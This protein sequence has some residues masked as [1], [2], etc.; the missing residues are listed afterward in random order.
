LN[1]KRNRT[2]VIAEAGVNHNGD[3]NIA[4][5]LID[6]ASKSGADYVKFQ[7]FDVDH[8]IL[9][10]TRTATYQKRNLKSNISQ[11]LMLKKYQLAENNYKELINFSKKKKIK[12]L[13]TAFDFKSLNFL[14]KFKLDYIK[15]PSGEITNLPFLK[16]IAK[17]NKKILLST[18]MASVREIKQALR[19]LGSKKKN[20]T[21]MHCTSDYP[22][23]LNDLN[24]NFIKE[25]KKFGYQVGY[26]DHSSS[27]ITPS[28]AVSLG[29]KVIEK[30]FTLSKKF[31]GPDHKAS[32]EPQELIKMIRLIRDTEKMLG[33]KNKII[34]SSEK[35][36]KLLVRKSLV[37][38]IDIKKGEIFN[39]KN[40]T[41][42]RPGTGISPFKIKKFLGKKSPK[43]FSKDQLIK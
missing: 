25:L 34:T 1:L 28:I 16:E 32:L 29:S 11:Y 21:I 2:I 19:V 5:K 39:T 40:I 14:K 20:I 10:N 26:S 7:T 38:R 27:I 35:K 12:F 43:N 13:S 3:I 4:K 24:L 15:I 30:H 22:A 8:L 33:T 9:K 17:L 42:K 18:G 6:I 23:N 41:T 31:K 36:T 37:A